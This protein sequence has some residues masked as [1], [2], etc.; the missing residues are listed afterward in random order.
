[1]FLIHIVSLSKEEAAVSRTRASLVFESSRFGKPK[2]GERTEQVPP[3]PD[4]RPWRRKQ[5]RTVF[6]SISIQY[7]STFGTF[8]DAHLLP[9]ATTRVQISPDGSTAFDLPALSERI[10]PIMLSVVVRAGQ[11]GQTDGHLYTSLRPIFS[12]VTTSSDTR[13]PWTETL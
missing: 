3:P 13:R 10:F 6:K 1:M 5:T 9:R 7:I 2:H 8:N 4:R 11:T 12:D